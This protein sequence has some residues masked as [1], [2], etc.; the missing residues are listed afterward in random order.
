VETHRQR[1]PIG[2][3]LRKLNRKGADREWRNSPRLR[4]QDR[5]NDEAN[6]AQLLALWSKK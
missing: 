1:T 2:C 5:R 3:P 4:K 6:R